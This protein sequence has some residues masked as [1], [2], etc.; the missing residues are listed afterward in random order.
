M[1]YN[2]ELINKYPGIWKDRKTLGRYLALVKF[3]PSATEESYYYCTICKKHFLT[4]L[5]AYNHI[6]VKH[7]KE[8]LKIIKK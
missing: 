6:D 8:I 2:P 3:N 1:K 7:E 5:G 4:E